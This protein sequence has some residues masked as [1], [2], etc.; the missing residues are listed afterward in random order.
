[1]HKSFLIW[2]FASSGEASFDLLYN[3]KDKFFVFDS[4]KDVQQRLISKFSSWKNVF[5]L[6]RVNKDVICSAI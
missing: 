4:N 6:T 1:M 2:G 3:K 5:V